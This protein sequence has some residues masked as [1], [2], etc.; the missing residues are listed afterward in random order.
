M[1]ET[2]QSAGLLK[3]LIIECVVCFLH[4]PPGINHWFLIPNGAIACPYSLD[5]ILTIMCIMRIYLSWRVF[6]GGSF[7][8]DERA[9]MICRDVCNTVGG[10]IFALKCEMKERPYQVI[11]YCQLCLILFFGY[12]IRASEL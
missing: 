11:L 7:W 10:P 1:L 6:I 8:G 5:M 3:Y 4:S 12:A 9:E 2:L